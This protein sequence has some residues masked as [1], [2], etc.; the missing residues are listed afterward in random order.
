MKKLIVS[1]LL[2]FLAACGHKDEGN[3]AWSHHDQNSFLLGCTLTTAASIPSGT[4]GDTLSTAYTIVGAYCNCVLEASMSRWSAADF[5][6]NAQA[7][8]AALTADG[9]KTGCENQASE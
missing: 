3:A 5:S 1:S 9:T 8:A 7:D 4:T 2:L 6:A